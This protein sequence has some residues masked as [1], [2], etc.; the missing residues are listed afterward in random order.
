MP[1]NKKS[2]QQKS[3]ARNRSVSPTIQV[4]EQAWDIAMKIKALETTR[5]LCGGML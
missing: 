5:T 3:K 2:R 1:K 4:L